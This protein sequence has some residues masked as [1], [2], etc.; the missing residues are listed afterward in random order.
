MAELEGELAA[1]NQRAAKLDTANAR[2]AELEGEL[3]AANQRA[4]KLDDAQGRIAALEAQVEAASRLK[5][6]LD[7]ANARVDELENDLAGTQ[8][9]VSGFADLQN[10]AG[11]MKGELDAAHQRTAELEGQLEAAHGRTTELEGEL[12]GT[13]TSAA[14]IGQ[15]RV[16]LTERDRRIAAMEASQGELQT[17][18]TERDSARSELDALRSELAQSQ[19]DEELALLK[20]TVGRR[21]T[22]IAELRASLQQQQT[23]PSWQRG[24]TKL[25]TP[26]AGHSDDLKVI[27]GI[28]PKM[29]GILNSFGITAWE[30]LA[31][32]GKGEVVE[33][34]EAL[35]F[36]PG[37][38]ERDEWVPQAKE[39]VK[40]FPDIETRPT[41]ETYLNRSDDDDPYN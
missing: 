35:D 2:S 20:A 8:S 28:G 33:V 19:N 23:A 5:G 29:E 34:N 27:N 21:D 40:E 7:T 16:D 6:D 18:I 15:L 26:G 1:A 3:A 12:A 4:A 36:F 24:T 38:I 14:E 11:E 22:T 10:Q 17:A 32:L 9:Q 37:R 41:R 30:Q 39:L 13:A 31:V 25:G